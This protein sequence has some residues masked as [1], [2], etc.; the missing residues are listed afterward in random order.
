MVLSRVI[1]TLFGVFLA[2]SLLVG[3]LLGG[4]V[5]TPYQSIHTLP[6]L[7][8]RAI[9]LTNNYNCSLGR[10]LVTCARVYFQFVSERQ[11]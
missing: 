2:R 1:Q 10:Q 7:P 9:P 8:C 6:S 5:G 11:Q 4:L 3:D